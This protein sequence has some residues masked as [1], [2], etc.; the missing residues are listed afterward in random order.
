MVV[1][2]IVGVLVLAGIAIL[3]FA[4]YKVKGRIVRIYYRHPEAGL[5]LDQDRFVGCAARTS[6]TKQAEAWVSNVTQASAT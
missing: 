3:C 2:L 4:A 6:G 1:V 5:V